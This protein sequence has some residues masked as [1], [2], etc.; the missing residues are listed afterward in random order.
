MP[1]AF[2]CTGESNKSLLAHRQHHSNRSFQDETLY[3]RMVSGGIMLT[4]MVL[5]YGYSI[6]IF[7]FTILA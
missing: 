5:Q 6:F 7:Q 1:S 4:I 2:L 3:E